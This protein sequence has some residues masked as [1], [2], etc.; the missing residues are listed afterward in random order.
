M[1]AKYIERDPETGLTSVTNQTTNV[2]Y[3]IKMSE[4]Q[5]NSCERAMSQPVG[6]LIDLDLPDGLTMD[7]YI[8]LTN[9]IIYTRQARAVVTV[10]GL[11]DR[12]SAIE[13]FVARQRYENATTSSQIKQLS[14]SVRRLF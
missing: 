2:T 5:W 7:Q 3:T 11:A 9:V 8:A 10:E 14:R 6:A 4:A 13:N 1:A 12:V